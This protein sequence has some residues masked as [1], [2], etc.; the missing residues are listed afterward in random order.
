MFHSYNKI[1]KQDFLVQNSELMCAEA[2]REV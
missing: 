2:R 1:H